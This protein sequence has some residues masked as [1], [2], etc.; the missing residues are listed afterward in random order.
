MINN[1]ILKCLDRHL[2][3]DFGDLEQEDKDL[4]TDALKDNLNNGRVVSKY[5]TSK[6][7]IYIITENYKGYDNIKL[8]TTIM[9]TSDY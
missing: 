2:N 9:L 7:D 4:N 3:N 1:E 6:A 8:L 5:I